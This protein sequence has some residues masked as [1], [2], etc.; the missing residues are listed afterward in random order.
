MDIQET[1]QRR[2]Q[3]R[4]VS[5]IP[6]LCF[7]GLTWVVYFSGLTSPEYQK[8]EAPDSYWVTTGAKEVKQFH[9]PDGTLVILGANSAMEV[10][11]RYGQSECRVHLSG[12]ARFEVASD[13]IKPFRVSTR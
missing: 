1:L 7:I 4:W 12:E 11:Y 8:M 2:R 6:F 13:T 3:G 10:P 5:A 9:L